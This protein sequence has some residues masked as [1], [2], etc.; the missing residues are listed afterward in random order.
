MIAFEN[1]EN[2]HSNQLNTY[3]NL[4]KQSSLLLIIYFDKIKYHYL[5]Y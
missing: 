3:Q 2:S 5:F 1:V 4:C